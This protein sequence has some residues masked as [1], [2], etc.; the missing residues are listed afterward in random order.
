[1]I[2]RLF[3]LL[4]VLALG[5]PSTAYSQSSF[6]T[7]IERCEDIR[8]DIEEILKEE[9][10][11]DYFFYLALAESGCDPDNKSEKNALGLFQLVPRTF[12]A[13]SKGVCNTDSFEGYCPIS[14]AYDPLI[15]T[16]VAAKYLKS[17]YDR[18]DGNVDWVIAAFNT[19]GTNLIKKTSYKK[20][21][22]IKV[23]K[24]YYPNAYNLAMTVRRFSVLDEAL[25]EDEDS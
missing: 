19:G 24:K 16:R 6:Y 10:L 2:S 7:Y 13:Y 11:P 8:D 3:L 20:G 17:L 4:F 14:S 9:G 25:K 23:V 15:S 18:F 12:K 22:D 21:M 5:I 1:M